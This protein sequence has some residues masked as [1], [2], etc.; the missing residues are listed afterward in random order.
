L[1][2]EEEEEEDWRTG[3]EDRRRSGYGDRW[4]GYYEEDR[5]S[6]YEDWRTA[7]DEK[8]EEFARSRVSATTKN[9][10]YFFTFNFCLSSLAING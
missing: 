3:Y 9:F 2:E 6:G 4:R 1:R 5:R 10:F 8:E 7:Y